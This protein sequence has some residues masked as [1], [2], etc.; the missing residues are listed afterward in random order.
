M[1][2]KANNKRS[3][4]T[5]AEANGIGNLPEHLSDSVLERLPIR[6]IIRTSILSK[7][8]RYK[9]TTTRALVFDEQFS[10]KLKKYGAF[11]RY[12]F[13]RVINQVLL[14]HKG[15]ISK[16]YL[17]IPS[18]HLDN[19]LEVDQWLLFLSTKGLEDLTLA[20]SSQPYQLPFC[21]FSCLELTKLELTRCIFKPPLKFEGFLFLES[22]VL[23]Y[24]DF[25]TQVGGTGINLPQLKKL[26]MRSCINAFNL[27]IKATQ[28][29]S[30]VVKNCH[31]VMLL[32]LLHSQWLASVCIILGK[33]IKDYVRLKKMNLALMF[34]HMPKVQCLSIDAHFLKV[35]IAEK[36][37]WFPHVVNNLKR[38][39]L[40]DFS[41]GDLDDLHGV[42]CLLRN[43][44]NLVELRMTHTETVK[45]SYYLPMHM[46]PGVE[47]ASDHLESPDCLDQTLD[48]LRTVDLSPFQ[49]SK[50]QLLYV[51][52]LLAHSP[53]L[54]K[55]TIQAD[56][57]LNGNKRFDIA[58]D[59]MRFP[60]AS[61]KAEMIYLDPKTC[62]NDACG[63][64]CKQDGWRKAKVLYL[65][66]Q[67]HKKV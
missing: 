63:Y 30:L 8:W 52:M 10:N 42:L 57:A 38:L 59:L 13:I 66:T 5:I 50:S 16:F 33:P 49:G 58:K 37:E 11:G 62:K 61:A 67:V 53:S 9:W 44:P 64:T 14:I 46:Q 17:Y 22:L 51:K 25:R 6:D 35:F 48:R 29:Q 31:D 26:T 7:K 27:Q 45:S 21:V 43:S 24:I 65:C 41:L 2:L 47:L 28:L 12:G 54:E 60:R 20:N 55:F 23:N 39:R 32:E 1:D 40:I 56:G 15:S 18:M 19:F 3:Q 36:P 4:V 34:S